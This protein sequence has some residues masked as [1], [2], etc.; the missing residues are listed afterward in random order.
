MEPVTLDQLQVFATVVEEGSFSGAARRLGRAQSAVSYAIAN[1][2]R[3]LEIEL[4]DRS[5]RKPVLTEAGRAL[6][7]DARA[8]NDRVDRLC[9]RARRFNEGVEPRVSL[10]I[11][12]MFPMSILLEALAEF[13][14]R[15]PDVSLHLRIEGLGAVIDLV[16]SGDVQIGISLEAEFPPDTTHRPMWS[17]PMVTVCAEN[18]PLAETPGPLSNLVVRD[19][20]QLVLTDRSAR[21]EG[22]DRGVLSENTWRVADLATKH[23]FLRAG[24]GWGHMPYHLVADDLQAGNLVALQLDATRLMTFEIGLYS[25]FRVADVPGPAG[26]WLIADLER[27]CE[28]APSLSP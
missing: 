12:V 15:F 13:R 3:L 19:Y 18:H 16:T 9:A 11:D 7:P 5:G 8:V 2:E 23:A 24:F 4:F 10:A 6:L 27:R 22:E 21:T 26:R 17:C 20:R 1:L 28:A 14:R 25:V